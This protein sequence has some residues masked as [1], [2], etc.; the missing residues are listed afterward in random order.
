M[1]TSP[2]KKHLQFWG[3]RPERVSEV[4]IFK[5]DHGV[6]ST[7]FLKSTGAKSWVLRSHKY[8][9]LI[10]VFICHCSKLMDSP[11]VLDP[12]VPGSRTMLPRLVAE[13]LGPFR[14]SICPLPRE[15]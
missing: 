4:S 9:T 3:Q 1:D 13:G 11:A 7:Y 10:Y 14:S 6:V 2:L 5:Y 15:G 12:D 8:G